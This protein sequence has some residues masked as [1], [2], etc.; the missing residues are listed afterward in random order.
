MVSDFVDEFNGLLTLTEGEFERG[1]L[2]YPDLKKKAR[3]LLKYGVESEGYW[4]NELMLSTL[5][6]IPMFFGFLI[7]AQA[8][9]LL[10][11]MPLM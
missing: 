2:M 9:Q 8:T 6:I 3:V 10:L 7:M 4:N 5:R 1:R 11:K